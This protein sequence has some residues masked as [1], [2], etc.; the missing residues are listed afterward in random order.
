MSKKRRYGL[1]KWTTKKHAREFVDFDY[2]DKIK[3]PEVLDWLN[4][5]SAEYYQVT[6]AKDDTALHKTQEEKRKLYNTNNAR[7]RDVM[8]QFTRVGLLQQENP[9]DEEEPT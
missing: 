6:I 4:R 7:Y 2:L 8:H 1:E 5:F 3:D 9:E